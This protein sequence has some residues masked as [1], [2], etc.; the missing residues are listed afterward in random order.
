V[1]LT[2]KKAFFGLCVAKRRILLDPYCMRLF[3]PMR[4]SLA[5]LVKIEYF[6]SIQVPTSA[7]LQ[8]TRALDN[9]LLK[10]CKDFKS[11]GVV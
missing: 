5:K 2:S 1:A 10:F 7:F 8:G 4:V 6:E 11:I 9:D 3:Y